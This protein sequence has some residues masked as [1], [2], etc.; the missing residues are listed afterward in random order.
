[1]FWVYQEPTSCGISFALIL[2]AASNQN[3]YFLANLMCFALRLSQSVRYN[4]V[5]LLKL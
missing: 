3:E 2:L 5:G 1:M 4:S